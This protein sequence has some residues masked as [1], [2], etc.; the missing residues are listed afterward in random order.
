[1]ADSEDEARS[2][3]EALEAAE[4]AHNRHGARRRIAAKQL[5]L[6][7]QDDSAEEDP[8]RERLRKIAANERLRRYRDLLVRS[9]HRDSRIA[10]RKGEKLR[11][12]S[13]GQRIAELRVSTVDAERADGRN[14]VAE[15]LKED[16]L[17]DGFEGVVTPVVFVPLRDAMLEALVRDRDFR[18]RRDDEVRS[19]PE[20][21]Q[22]EAE[23]DVEGD[24][25]L[26]DFLRD[27]KANLEFRWNAK[28]GPAP[29]DAGNDPGVV[30]ALDELVEPFEKGELPRW[31]A[32]VS[33][34]DTGL[35][36]T[37]DDFYRG[38]EGVE[39]DLVRLEAFE[40]LR[41]TYEEADALGI[42]LP[43]SRKGL[44]L[45]ANGV[46]K[47]RKGEGADWA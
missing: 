15:F 24:L 29:L 31:F 12:E 33:D 4:K 19:H 18:R 11:V 14:A 37:L 28:N 23:W 21:L 17:E 35:S 6:V 30:K 38:D 41:D 40:R 39:D 47:L 20:Y 10:F 42:R 22:R 46:R 36:G 43:R 34:E 7:S 44:S 2:K 5:E 8:E 26:P 32:E 27:V 9:A 1:M 25:S 45:E 3:V 13:L 16:L